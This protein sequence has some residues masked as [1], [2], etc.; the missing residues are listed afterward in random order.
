MNL[1]SRQLPVWGCREDFEVQQSVELAWKYV[2]FAWHEPIA[3]SFPLC[4][5]CG[6]L[7]GFPS[8]LIWSREE[9]PRNPQDSSPRKQTERLKK[10]PPLKMHFLFMMKRI[11][12]LDDEGENF[13]S[14][15][16]LDIRNPRSKSFIKDCNL[17]VSHGC[18]GCQASSISAC[19]AVLSPPFLIELCKANDWQKLH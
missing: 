17:A 10:S 13:P 16:I 18:I 1:V 8:K 14:G 11:P 6:D 4:R 3:L 19:F 2:G 15:H 12:S 5:E 7:P 9:W